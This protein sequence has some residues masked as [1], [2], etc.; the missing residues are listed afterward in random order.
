[1]YLGGLTANLFRSLQCYQAPCS[2]YDAVLCA[3]IGPI[4]CMA[5]VT[6]PK[7]RRKGGSEYRERTFV[8]PSSLTLTGRD[9]LQEHVHCLGVSR[10]MWMGKRGLISNTSRA[11]GI[12][13][14]GSTM[15]RQCPKHWQ[16]L[17]SLNSWDMNRPKLDGICQLAYA[18]AQN[19]DSSAVLPSFHFISLSNSG[20]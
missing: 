5:W 12:G 2:S 15:L 3:E 8:C 9:E 10:Q 14:V 18:V 17:A 16:A 20:R 4:R 19:G 1:L 13:L 11:S 7:P 6:H